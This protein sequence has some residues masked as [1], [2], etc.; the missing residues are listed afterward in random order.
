M[1]WLR[2]H[3]KAVFAI[4]IIM[5]IILV[6]TGVQIFRTLSESVKITKK[7]GEAIVLKEIK[8]TI[9][10]SEVEYDNFKVYYEFKVINEHHNEIDVTVDA[11]TGKIIEMEYGD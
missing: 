1:A 7:E 10:E 4:L 6:L 3:N 9:I 11:Q 5:I 2:K 8:G